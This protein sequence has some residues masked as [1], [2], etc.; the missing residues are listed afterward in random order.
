MSFLTFFSFIYFKTGLS[1]ICSSYTKDQNFVSCRYEV[2]LDHYKTKNLIV[3]QLDIILIKLSIFMSL[4][5]YF[6]VISSPPQPHQRQICLWHRLLWRGSR[7]FTD[8]NL[9]RLKLR[10]Q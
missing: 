10:C 8:Q 3:F 7:V 4:H 9:P 1:A 6:E 5:S 2:A